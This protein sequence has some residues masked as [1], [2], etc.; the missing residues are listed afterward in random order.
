MLFRSGAESRITRLEAG[1]DLLARVPVHP[2]LNDG[3]EFVAVRHSRGVV[4]ETRVV[5]EVGPLDGLE[6]PHGERLCAR[7]DGDPAVVFRAVDVPRCRGVRL[8]A[9]PLFDFAEE[10]QSETTGERASWQGKIVLIRFHIR[11]PDSIFYYEGR[12]L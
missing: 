10:L 6:R 4:R 9:R 7:G 3:V 1:H 12:K 8:V 5:S 2:L 11:H